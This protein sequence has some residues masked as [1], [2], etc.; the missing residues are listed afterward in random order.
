MAIRKE[1]E[2]KDAKAQR[3]PTDEDDASVGT[4]S[5]SALTD[6]EESVVSADDLVHEK[7]FKE[8]D[9]LHM[10]GL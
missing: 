9:G 7:P 1:T 8:D 3:V 2:E 10:T 5:T 4:A 6:D